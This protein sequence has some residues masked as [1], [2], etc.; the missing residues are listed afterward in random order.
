MLGVALLLARAVLALVFLVSGSA[1]LFDRSRTTRAA[2]EFG[3]PAPVAVAIGAGLPVVELGLAVA[4]LIPASAA[5]A[6]LVAFAL[7]AAF[8]LATAVALVRGRK[9]ECNCFGMLG[10]RQTVTLKSV[11]RNVVLMGLAAFS[12]ATR[13]EAGRLARWQWLTSEPDTARVSL[14]FSAGLLLVTAILAAVLFQVI[15]QNGRILLRLDE[16]ETGQRPANPATGTVHTVGLPIG[17]PAPEFR[18]AGLHGEVLTLASQL[19]VGLPLLL[20]FTDP[21]CGPC[22]ALLPQLS[23]WERELRGRAAFVTISRGSADQN[24]KKYAHPPGTVLLQQ[25]RE[26]ATA[27]QAH[28]TPS[29]VLVDTGGRIASP[30]AA[31]A[32][33]IR[34]LAD[35]LRGPVPQPSGHRM[36]QLTPLG[37]PA[38]DVPLTSLSGKAANLNDKRPNDTVA[39]FWNLGCGFCQKMLPD[40]IAWEAARPPG[41]PDL[42]LISAGSAEAN[43]AMALQSTILLDHSFAAGRAVGA[44]GTPSAVVISRSGNLLSSVVVGAPGVLGL[45]KTPTETSKPGMN[46]N[47]AGAVHGKALA[48][49]ADGHVR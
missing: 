23:E 11:L 38:P 4:I 25:D 35:T 3:A 6:S 32:E 42:L 20:T 40:L 9:V 41:S 34:K 48:G 18:L 1:K 16:L 12:F 17:S 14:A 15:Q 5:L 26:I 13:G 31:G 46:T 8:T 30:V 44:T 45:L 22:T 21:G 28:G 19:A 10:G 2:R 33:A 29:A 36:P 43:R 37:G 7:L 49:R 24:L 27:Y 47:G 39:L